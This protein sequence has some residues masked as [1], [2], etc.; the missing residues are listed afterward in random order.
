ME[1]HAVLAEMHLYN[2]IS[3]I[4]IILFIDVATKTKKALHP[5]KDD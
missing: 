5:N 2:S 1:L 4:D 3:F